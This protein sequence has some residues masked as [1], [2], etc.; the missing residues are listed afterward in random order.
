MYEHDGRWV[1]VRRSEYDGDPFWEIWEVGETGGRKR[2]VHR[3]MKQR[4]A[5]GALMA[6]GGVGLTAAAVL[7]WI[8]VGPYTV[9]IVILAIMVWLYL[10]AEYGN[11]SI[12][13][14]YMGSCLGLWGFAFSLAGIALWKVA[15]KVCV[16]AFSALFGLPCL[17]F[18]VMAWRARR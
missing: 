4:L 1:E 18:G 8:A 11:L 6:V 2:E 5:A 13:A 16:G 10:E 14:W 15:P 12:E 7:C 17:F 3:D 9:P